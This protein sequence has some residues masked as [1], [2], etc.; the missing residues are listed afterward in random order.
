MLSANR[1]KLANRSSVTLSLC[2]IDCI[3]ARLS[4]C[5]KLANSLTS[6]TYMPGKHLHTKK[7]E[8]TPNIQALKPQIERNRK[9]KERKAAKQIPPRSEVH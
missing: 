6:L 7:G 8:G 2:L 4:A 1:K 5:N 9:E 3:S